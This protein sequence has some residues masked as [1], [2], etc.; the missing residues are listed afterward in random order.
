MAVKLKVPLIVL[1]AIAALLVLSIGTGS[2]RPLPSASVSIGCATGVGSATVTVTLFTNFTL[3]VPTGTATYTCGPNSLS[4]L[5]RV[6]A[7][8]PSTQAY[9]FITANVV[10]TTAAGSGGCFLNSVPTLKDTCQI[11]ATGPAVSIT[12]R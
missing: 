11:L 3:L 1:A 7:S 10:M 4:G 12:V 2:A 6:R 5:N 9:G 8:L